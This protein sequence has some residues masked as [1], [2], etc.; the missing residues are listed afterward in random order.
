ML[1]LLLVAIGVA[2]GAAAA[3]AA[4]C[5]PVTA[6]FLALLV[7]DTFF[8]SAGLRPGRCFLLLALMSFRTR[9]VV[10]Q[11]PHVEKPHT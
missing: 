3:G 10:C 8:F 5:F 2:G 7:L 1:I 4:F 11:L 6:A 9:N